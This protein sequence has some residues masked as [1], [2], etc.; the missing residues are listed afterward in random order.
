MFQTKLDVFFRS[1]YSISMAVILDYTPSAAAEVGRRLSEG[2]VQR[3]A[4][5]RSMLSESPVLLLDEATSALDE[6]TEKAFLMNLKE[7][8]NVTCIIV[9][10]KKAALEICN[11]HVRIENSKIIYQRDLPKYNAAIAAYLLDGIIDVKKDFNA[12]LIELMEKGIIIKE[13]EE[14]IVKDINKCLLLHTET[15]KFVASNLNKKINKR[16]F[17]KAVLKDAQNLSLITKGDIP[18]IG[19]LLVLL[20]CNQIYLFI[21]AAIYFKTSLLQE[22]AYKLTPKGGQEKDKMLKLKAFLHNFS[23]IENVTSLEHNIW[24]RYLPFAIALDESD[25]PK[26]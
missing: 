21:L 22:L 13:N 5:A 11:K 26:Y 25:F 3:L 8:K 20:F 16:A 7:M 9:S 4:I 19:M 18:I 24:D 1:V 23:Q 17:K 2:Q 10:H 12:L 14:Y 6:E 15:E